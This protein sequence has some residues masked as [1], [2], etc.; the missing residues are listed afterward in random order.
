MNQIIRAQYRAVLEPDVTEDALAEAVAQCHE[1][2]QAEATQGEILT[3]GMFRYQ[4]RLFLYLEYIA[5]EGDDRFNP[6][7]DLINRIPDEWFAFMRPLLHPWPEY[8]GEQRWAY[9]YP[10]FWTDEPRSLTQWRRQQAPD[11]RCGRIAVLYPDKFASYICHHHNLVTEGLLVGDRYQMI[12]AHENILFSYFE[13]PRDRERVNIRRSD[14]PS[15]A[16]KAWE[17]VDPDSHFQRFPE[18]PNNNFLI[19]ETLISVGA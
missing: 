7:R 19:I 14:E 9:M 2:L 5:S 18:D 10:V 15:Q 6:R 8:C 16:I 12:S 1:I 4:D 17:A 13:T 3:G 11:A